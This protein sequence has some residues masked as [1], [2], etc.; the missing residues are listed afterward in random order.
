MVGEWLVHLLKIKCQRSLKV[1]F[2]IVQ[3]TSSILGSSTF[4]HQLSV[5]GERLNTKYLLT[6][7]VKSLPRKSE[8]MIA[9][10]PDMTLAVYCE[11]KATNQTNYCTTEDVPTQMTILN[12]IIPILM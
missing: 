12:T 2:P 5:S 4:C 8:V 11:C 10:C 7:H 1:Q 9:D 6:A 3:L